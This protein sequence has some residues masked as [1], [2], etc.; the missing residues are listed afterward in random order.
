MILRV[1]YLIGAARRGPLP[2]VDLVVDGAEVFVELS[3]VIAI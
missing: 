2:P 1:S 3:I